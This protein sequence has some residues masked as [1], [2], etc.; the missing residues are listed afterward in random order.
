MPSFR[1]VMKN[2]TS[3]TVTRAMDSRIRVQMSLSGQKMTDRMRK[4]KPPMIENYCSNLSD[5]LY[6]MQGQPF[7]MGY[8]MSLGAAHLTA[9]Q[10]MRWT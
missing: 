4:D 6:W 5:S 7:S 8:P 3:I 1:I 10:M 2:I 9:L